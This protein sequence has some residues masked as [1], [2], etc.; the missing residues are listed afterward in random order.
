MGHWV[1][2]KDWF[3]SRPE[4]ESDNVVLGVSGCMHSSSFTDLASR[5]RCYCGLARSDSLDGGLIKYS[6]QPRSLR[7]PQ[8]GEPRVSVY[9]CWPPRPRLETS[10]W[11]SSSISQI[12]GPW[13]I[14]WQILIPWSCSAQIRTDEKERKLEN[15]SKLRP[16]TAKLATKWVLCSHQDRK[17]RD[18]FGNP[19][20]KLKSCLFKFRTYFRIWLWIAV[21]SFSRLKMRETATG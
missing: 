11:L 16:A 10:R 13:G 14:F 18:K 12:P 20:L 9:V 4:G 17:K 19:D 7:S 8:S 2:K 3:R 1:P 21:L 6:V 15:L 5:G